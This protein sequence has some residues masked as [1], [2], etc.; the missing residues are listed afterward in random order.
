MNMIFKRTSVRKYKT[1]PVSPEQVELLLK[2]GMAAPSAMNVQPW[3]F[4][5]VQDR[6][7]L[8]K[9]MEIHPYSSMLKEAPLAII[10]CANTEKAAYEGFAEKKYWLQDCSAAT[11]NIMLQ[12]A[13]MDLGSVWLGT[14]PKEEIYQPISKIFNLPNNVVPVT[15]IALGH[16][17]EEVKPKDKFN[18]AK[19]HY[20]KW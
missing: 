16:P 8:N 6:K 7:N 9:I 15:I 2:A 17:D 1:E 4:I 11:Q 10:V 18:K 19:I 14:Y 20:E 13:E 3:E 5:V 12:A